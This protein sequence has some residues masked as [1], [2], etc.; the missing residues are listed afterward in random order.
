MRQL[1]AWIALGASALMAQTAELHVYRA[2]MLPSNEVGNVTLN[3]SAMTTVFVHVIKD[4]T[5]AIVSGSVDF[6]THA[7]FTSANTVTGLHIHAAPAGTNGSIVLPTDV[8]SIPVQAGLNDITRQ[9][10]VK[11]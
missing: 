10:E 3:G 11:P 6:L 7:T 5:G 4:N 9:V 2:V 8:S 1:L